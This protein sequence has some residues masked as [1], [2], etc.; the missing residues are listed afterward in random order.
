MGKGLSVVNAFLLR[1][2]LHNQ[3]R[4]MMLNNTFKGKFGPVD[5]SNTSQHYFLVVEELIPKCD[6]LTKNPFLPA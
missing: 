2:H 3:E 4:F 5:P 6:S 1:K